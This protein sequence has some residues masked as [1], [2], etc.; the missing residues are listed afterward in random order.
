MKKLTLTILACAISAQAFAQ[1]STTRSTYEQQPAANVAAEGLRLGLVVPAWKA[2]FKANFLGQTFKSEKYNFDNIV[3]IEAGYARL[4][5]G[6]IGFIVNG[7]YANI[8]EE[9]SDTGLA[10]VE[11]NGA[12]AATQNLYFKAG[13]NISKIVTGEQAS[14]WDPGFGFQAGLGFQMTKNLGAELAYSEMNQSSS[15]KGV[16]V[17]MKLAGPEAAIT[18]T[19]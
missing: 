15:T 13:V 11:G 7:T 12:F 18:G 10:R 5:V 14:D 16:N 4:P 9:N 3:G 6:N 19:F 2:Q 17:D 8:H 1:P